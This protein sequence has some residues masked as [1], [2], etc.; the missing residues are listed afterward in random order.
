MVLIKSMG[1]DGTVVCAVVHL[2]STPCRVNKLIDAA[3]NSRLQE[4]IALIEE[5][6]V[7]QNH[8]DQWGRTAQFRA[9]YRGHLRVVRWLVG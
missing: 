8:R 1:S 9:S 4:M 6:G 3:Q 2:L 5:Q 7:D